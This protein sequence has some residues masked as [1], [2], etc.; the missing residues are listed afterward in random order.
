MSAASKSAGGDVVIDLRPFNTF[1]EIKAG[2]EKKLQPM[3]RAP[4]SKAIIYIGDRRLTSKQKREIRDIMLDYGVHLLELMPSGPPLTSEKA[5][6][7]SSWGDTPI[8]GEAALICGNLRSGQKHFVEKNLVILGDIN[9]GAEILAGGNILVMGSLR[10][11]AHAGVFGDEKAVIV[12]Y[13]MSPTQLRIANHI[14]RPPDGEVVEQHVPE[15]A[16][17]RAGK[18]VIEKIKI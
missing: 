13:R 11:M 18:V 6:E 14:T 4:G 2:L 15:M 9:P 8:Y 1:A 3:E 17:I 7:D 10:G 12:A 16:R 5:A